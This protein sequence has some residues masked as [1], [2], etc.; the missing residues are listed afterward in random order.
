[1][2]I[3]VGLIFGVVLIAWMLTRATRDSRATVDGSSGGDV[4]PMIF[5]G[6]TGDSY[7]SQDGPV[8]CSPDVSGGDFSGGGADCGGGGDGGG[9]GGGGD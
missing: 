5:S 4:S 7:G 1:M 2:L 3:G 8:D 9:G 6:H